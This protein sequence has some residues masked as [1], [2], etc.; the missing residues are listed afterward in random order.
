MPP[1]KGLFVDEGGPWERAH[2]T[3]AIVP[4]FPVTC[5]CGV[6]LRD[7]DEATAHECPADDKP[8]T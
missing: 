6:E 3:P 2:G 5:D 1:V 7:L 4:L 8:A